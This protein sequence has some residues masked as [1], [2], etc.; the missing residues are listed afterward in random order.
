M[1]ITDVK[2]MD[3]VFYSDLNSGDVF[4]FDS[5]IYIKTKTNLIGGSLPSNLVPQCLAVNLKTGEYLSL[6]L[7]DLVTP[8]N[9]EFKITR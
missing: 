3:K 7:H 5:S 4:E 2:F 1:K 9:G 6:E 8:V